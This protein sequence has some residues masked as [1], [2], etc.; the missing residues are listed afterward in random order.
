MEDKKANT[1]TIN[2]NVVMENREKVIIT[3]IIDIHSFDDELVL[4]ETEM[5]ILTIKGKELKMNKLNLDNTELIVEGQ[6]IMLQYNEVEHMKKGGMFNK[7]F[8]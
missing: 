8:R 6:I 1:G 3:G 4:T 7:I 5:G 2:H